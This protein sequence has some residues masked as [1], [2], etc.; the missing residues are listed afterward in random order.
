VIVSNTTP[1]SCLLKIGKADLLHVLF[2]TVA[3]P[4]EVAAELDEAAPIHEDW[5]QQLGFV[6]VAEATTDDP[7][8]RLLMAEIDL[9][10][11]AAIALARRINSEL[12]IVDDMAGRRLAQQLGLTI[13]GTVGVVL[14]AAE[15]HLVDD[16]FVVL[17]DLRARGGLW[18]SD[19][20]IDK[21]RSVWQPS[22]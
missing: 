7:V 11:S 17:D 4:P 21:L 8:M 18:L 14:A 2:G 12:L 15:R 20:F 10:E 6:R 1:L 5:R 9:G 13:T 22:P 3:I 16:P 19:S